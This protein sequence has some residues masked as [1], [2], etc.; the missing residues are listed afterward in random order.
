MVMPRRSM[1][2]SVSFLVFAAPLAGTGN[3]AAQTGSAL[4]GKVTAGQDTLEGVLVSAKKDGSNITVTVVSDKDGRY[5][6]PA[7]R[8]EPGQYS[9]RIRAA[10]Y[11]LANSDPVSVAAD[12][13]ATADLTLRKTEDLASQLS[14]AEWLASMPGTDAQ[15]GQ[16]LNCVGCHKL[17]RPL[18]SSYSADDFMTIILP[19][20]QGYVNQSIP[21]HPQLRRAERLMEERGDQRVQVYRG[22]AEF[23]ASIN[24]SSRPQ[25][26]FELKTLPRPTGAATRVVYTEYDL[27]R[28]TISPH[29][30]IVDANGM[31]WYS[32]F[33]EQNLGRLDPKT[34]KVTEFP[35]E[36]HKPGFPTG[37]LGLRSDRDGNLW[38]GNMYQATIVK[39]DRK[40]E[41]FKFWPLQGEGNIDAAQINMV[42]PQSSG[43]DGKVWTQN[44]GFAG[45]HRLDIATGAIET[46]EPFSKVPGP[47]NIYDVIPDSKNNAFFTD[48]RQRHI[49]RIDAGSGEIK[50]F[51]TP[52]PDSAPRRGTMD[53][54][55]RLWFGEYRGD[56]IGMFDTRTE[57]FKEWPVSP[58]WSAPYD[59]ITDKNGEAWT[60]SML[61]DQVTRLNPATGESIN[62][63]LPRNTNIRRVFVDNSTT[64]VTFWAGSNHGA[65][66]VKVEPLE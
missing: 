20:M 21:A 25:W 47:H 17:E 24:L 27:P 46:W 49:G 39:F 50:L 44:N 64:P 56:R 55:D 12:K 63:L 58:K 8:L 13:T 53:A 43:V 1:V 19:R 59:V 15:K 3:L 26:N 30:V 14:N 5:S 54:Q 52:M 9:L 61:S 11:D 36:E 38:L 45:V 23:L 33:G 31:V 51:A 29:D 32:S 60:G 42:S 22:A 4:S 37:L 10:G 62:Y 48:F 34:G 16:L 6:F 41:T 35:I 65:S 57:Q 18:R 2:T 7:A 28:E 66:I 40:T